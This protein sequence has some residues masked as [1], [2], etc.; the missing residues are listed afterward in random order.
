MNVKRSWKGSLA[1]AE[2]TR[3]L[4]ANPRFEEGGIQEKGSGR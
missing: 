4:S 1:G 2:K 3:D